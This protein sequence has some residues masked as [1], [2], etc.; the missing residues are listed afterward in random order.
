MAKHASPDDNSFLISVGKHLGAAVGLVA[1]VAG[2]FWGIGQ[3]QTEDPGD[4]TP[5]IANP[6][7]SAPTRQPSSDPTTEAPD[8]EPTPTPTPTPEPTSE[9]SSPE[10]SPQPSP[11]PSPEPSPTEA[12]GRIAASSIS[13]QVLDAVL[14]DGSAAASDVEQRMKA[15]GY[16]VVARNKASK[17]Y[18]VT[19]VFYSAGSEAQAQQIAEQYGW[20]R[21]EGKPDNLSDSV[22]VHVVVGADEA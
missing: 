5:V 15:D 10:P 17:T 8:P 2:A 3:V 13:V 11:E 4:D 21:V 12:D 1:V 18:D 19:T 7:T 22:Q 9:A 6:A 16:R 20:S 14:D